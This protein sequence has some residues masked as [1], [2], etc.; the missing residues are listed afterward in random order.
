MSWGQPQEVSMNATWKAWW[1][2][3]AALVLWASPACGAD[4]VGRLVARIRAV[5]GEGAGNAEA[6]AAW[7]ELVRL[8]PGALPEVLAALDDAGPVAANWL[9]AAVDAVAE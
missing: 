6:A 3:G 4:Q 5:G 9:R 2:V 1:A 8:G 7:K